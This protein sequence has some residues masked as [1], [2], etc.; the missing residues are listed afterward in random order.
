MAYQPPQN[1]NGQGPPTF[2]ESG[3]A[4][5]PAQQSEEATQHVLEEILGGQ[6]P[7]AGYLFPDD[8]EKRQANLIKTTPEVVRDE[9]LRAIEVC[10]QNVQMAF[11]MEKKAEM[12]RVA[13]ELSQAYLLL[14]PSVDN[15]GIPIE[16][17]AEID[18][19]TKAHEA[20]LEAHKAAHASGAAFELPGN[21]K[22]PPRVKLPPA[23]QAVS[24]KNKSK[25]N[26][27]KATKASK[28]TPKP[29]SGE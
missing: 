18:R 27:L 23:A 2:D 13:L 22:A 25:A 29:R 15:Q 11:G 16:A 19:E 7:G 14:D 20:N 12:G 4:M 3:R 26:M 28:P 6:I 1:G 17:K 5:T 10:A 24:E 9:L 8:P 21:F